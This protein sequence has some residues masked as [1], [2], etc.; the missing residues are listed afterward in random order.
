VRSFETKA[1][2]DFHWSSDPR[3]APIIHENGK[4][5][6]NKAMQERG[7]LDLNDIHTSLNAM[8]D[9]ND[10]IY[11]GLSGKDRQPMYTIVHDGKRLVY[12]NKEAWEA[13]VKKLEEA[14]NAIDQ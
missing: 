7:I 3:V 1:A 2:G 5:Y 14:A 13:D 12:D 11:L 6:I 10:L 8:T 4:W 9:L